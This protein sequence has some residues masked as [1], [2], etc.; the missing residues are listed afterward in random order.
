M[1][2]QV[3]KDSIDLGIVTTNGPAMLAFYR[4]VVGLPH[5]ADMPMPG[6]G[7]MHRLTCGTS[8]IKLV[9]PPR[10]PAGKAAPGGLAGA[11]GL[12]YWT[13]TVSNLDAVVAAAQAAGHSVPVPRRAVRPGVEIAMIEDPD[14]NWLELLEAR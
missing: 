6:G 5:A 8:V 10:A 14:G 7:T 9:V 2:I 13:V 3:T 4:D 11:T 12:R 1:P